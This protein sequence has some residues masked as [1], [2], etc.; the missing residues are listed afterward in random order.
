MLEL[1]VVMLII[2]ILATMALPSYYTKLVRDQVGSITPLLTVAQAPV[3]AE[4]S[5]KQVMPAN[6]AAAGLPAPDLMVGNYV[7]S[8][9]IV[10]G[11]VDITFS[12]RAMPALKGKVLSYRPAIVPGQPLV[13]ITWVCGYATAPEKMV[14]QGVN[15][16]TV[17]KPYLPNSCQ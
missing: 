3:A 2:G 5:A 17:P 16:T 7:S 1:L 15:A 12:K 14:A 10:N 9:Q 11:A 8:V 13:P 6:N 4:W